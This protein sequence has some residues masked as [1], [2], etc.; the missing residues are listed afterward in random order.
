MAAGI[1]V[2]RITAFLTHLPRQTKIA[3]Q[4][5][6]D[7]TLITICFIFAILVRLES[8][9]MLASA[10][11]WFALGAT[12][13]ATLV[14]FWAFG[15]YRVLVRYLTGHILTA[16]SCGAIKAAISLYVFGM[17]FDAGLPRSV[18]L[19]F[20]ALLF[21]CIGGIR[22]GVRSL[23]RT[24]HAN[25]RKPV[26]IYGA[27]ESG[28][29][30]LNALSFG[31][32]YR[33]VALVDDDPY[34]QN[35]T[36][37]G[38][39][40]TS[41]AKLPELVKKTGAGIVL[42]A[43]PSIG[44]SRRRNIVASLEDLQLQIKTIPGMS[45]IISGRAKI[46]ELRSISPEDL[47]GRDPVTPD[48]GLMEKNIAGRV[49]MV[50]G[51]G[52]SIG[53]ELCRQILR[54]QP[55]TLI[56]FEMSEFGLYAIET[57]LSETAR[58]LNLPT[59]IM[60]ILGSVQNRQKLETLIGTM[61][62]QTIYHAAA[63]KHVPLVEENVVEAVRNNVFGTMVLAAAARKFGVRNFI[64]ISTDK[65]VRPTNVMGATKRIAELICQAHARDAAATVFSMVR[66]GNVLG[67]SGS[68][69][70]R[71]RAQI[72]AGGPV[73]V[74]HKDI[75]RYFMT[76]P[77]AAQLVIQA[78]AMGRGGDVFVL[79]M[80]EPVKIL[81][82]AM[83]MV[84]LHGLTPYL[85]DA[86]DQGDIAIK[87]TGLR[88][89]EKLYEELLIGD[90]PAETSHPRI[91]TASETCIPMDQLQRILKRLGEACDDFDLPSIIAII[92]QL[93]VSY[94]PTSSDISDLQWNAMADANPTVKFLKKMAG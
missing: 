70:P 25:G 48:A 94:Q 93:P 43:M 62:V 86:P 84:K 87:V 1:P 92:H 10:A 49:V 3:L 8:V 42:L 23:F 9:A 56:L 71:F 24:P 14:T 39:R 81:D 72:E 12:I 69:I 30:L 50:T 76:I 73:T 37:G 34:L 55:K 53:S 52:G 57:E 89:G 38:L 68:V 28:R 75:T 41:P 45:D 11:V 18:P 51:A 82:L 44:R 26:I 91:M 19:I 90:N 13:V 40:V 67:S 32:E 66:F 16:V 61:Q 58:R 7:A 2:Q 29:Q 77:E 63:Y 65:A 64:L 22:F 4:L 17:I 33:A 31:R 15:L 35:L 21:I 79:D 5:G 85:A 59:Q 78:G 47:L 80:G 46:S 83:T 27:G 60:P 6:I 36:L 74:T 20:A 88:K 54:M